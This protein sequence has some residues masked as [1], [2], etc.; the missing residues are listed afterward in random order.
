M[1]PRVVISRIHVVPFS[2][3]ANGR[4]QG[5]QLRHEPAPF[6]L[7]A[8]LK[9]SANNNNVECHCHSTVTLIVFQRSLIRHLSLLSSEVGK[10]AKIT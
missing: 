8:T 10:G 6:E 7:L 3:N 2:V 1:F 4:F 5:N 9:L